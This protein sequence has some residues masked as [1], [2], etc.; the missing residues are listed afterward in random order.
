SLGCTFFYLLTGRPPFTGAT[1][2]QKL[3]QHQE[4]PPPPV[5]QL[6]PDVPEELAATLGKMLAKRPEDRFQ[7]PLLVVAA[8]RRFARPVLAPA[9]GPRPGSGLNLP[10]PG[11]SHE[12]TRPGSS[13]NLP[14]PGS[15]LDLGRPA[16][17]P[18][19]PDPGNGTY[20]RR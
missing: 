19:L 18:D 5:Q 2:M 3:L 17:S 12:I 11:S 6:R 4:E 7:I 8:L 9:G 14:R 1:L 20:P 15:G 10:R 13:L 16:S